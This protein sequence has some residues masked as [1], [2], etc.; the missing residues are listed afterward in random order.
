MNVQNHTVFADPVFESQ[1]AFRC[2]MNAMARPGS[3]QNLDIKISPP[4]GLPV[5]AAATILTLYDFETAIWVC[6]TIPNCDVIADYC[7]FHTGTMRAKSP[8]QAQFALVDVT[9][10][11]LCLANFAQGVAEYPDRSATIICVVPSLIGGNTR[12][13]TGPGIQSIAQLFVEGL[14]YDFDRQ[15]VANHASFPLGVDLIFC[16]GQS[17]VAL[18]RSARIMEN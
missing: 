8:D 16:C 3:I 7:A 14:P 18:P 5:A 9:S 2:V 1:Q 6:P 13:F 11:P 17:L 12:N 15:Q 10:N 4:D